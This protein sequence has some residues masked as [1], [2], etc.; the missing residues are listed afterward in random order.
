[1]RRAK[2]IL[3]AAL[4]I[5][6]GGCVLAG[7]PKAAANPP[8][9]PKP[10]AAAPKP[11]SL[12]IPQTQVELP[13]PQPLNPEALTTATPEPAPKTQQKPA[14]PAV[15]PPRTNTTAPKPPETTAPPVAEPPPAEPARAPIHEIMDEKE[16]N[17]LREEA[18]VHQA[19]TRKLL[20]E[21]R[22]QTN[23]QQR[24]V[25][26]ISQFLKQSTE[27][28]SAGDMRMADQL[29]ERAHILAKELQSGK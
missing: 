14:A 1:M 11:E 8:A 9:A 28:E 26:E 6:L 24:A 3:I 16:R 4:A 21:A 7:K 25:A 20:R 15:R 13:P 22:P 2:V 27:A 12:S 10:A 23:N 29:A 19:E 18:H 17:R 5:P